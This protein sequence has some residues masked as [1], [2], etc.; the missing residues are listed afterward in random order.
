LVGRQG[1]ASNIGCGCGLGTCIHGVREDV[2]QQRAGSGGAEL[3]AVLQVSSS[4]NWSARWCHR[5]GMQH[6]KTSEQIASNVCAANW[7]RLSRKMVASA[8]NGRL[9]VCTCCNPVWQWPQAGDVQRFLRPRLSSSQHC[10]AYILFT[11]SM[12]SRFL[13]HACVQGCLQPR[14]CVQGCV[15]A[16]LSAT[17]TVCVS[18]TC[19]RRCA[20]FIRL[21]VCKAVCMQGCLHARLS[22]TKN[23][24]V[25]AVQQGLQ[26]RLC[27][28]VC[29][30][31]CVQGCM[32]PRLCVCV[33][34]RLCVYM[35]ARLCVCK[36]V[37]VQ[38][39][40]RR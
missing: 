12:A 8:W 37:C 5:N 25:Q 21:C 38:G 39:C 29:T 13:R 32:Q 31:V 20:N 33:C 2:A 1:G 23:V 30:A 18:A 14:L 36:A 11:H 7:K 28:C 35:C 10:K 40:V 4:N 15:C 9:H 6:A 3:A 16:R 27:V 17:K 26:P 22:A 19:F 34:A 24:F